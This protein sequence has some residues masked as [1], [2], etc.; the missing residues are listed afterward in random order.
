MDWKGEGKRLAS[1]YPLAD[2][3]AVIRPKVASLDAQATVV[4]H[5]SVPDECVYHP[6]SLE[7]LQ[8]TIDRSHAA[9]VERRS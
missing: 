9:A 2:F 8:P 1:L 5:P 6:C 3:D 7:R 4:S